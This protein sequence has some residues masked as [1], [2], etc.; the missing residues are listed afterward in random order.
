MKPIVK[1]LTI[2]NVKPLNNLSLYMDH[3]VK[4]LLENG[5]ITKEVIS[6]AT[7]DFGEN[8]PINEIAENIFAVEFVYLK[9]ANCNSKLQ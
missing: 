9:D 7:L 1:F 8:S 3:V 2:N 6:Q 5:L 4:E